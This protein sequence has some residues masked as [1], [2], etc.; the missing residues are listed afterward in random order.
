[1]SERIFYDGEC[2]LCHGFVRFVVARDRPGRFRFAPL[3]GTTYS[4]A[5][6]GERRAGLPDSIVVA[7]ADGRVLARSDAVAHVLATLGGG[8]RTL[9]RM[10]LLVPRPLRD[11]GYD[12][13]A[14]VRRRLFRRP[15]DLC[16]VVPRA[17]RGRFEP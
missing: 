6:P 1:V 7:A 10:L 9:A 16:P 15:P 3:Q 11:L 8:W 12:A 4:T 5:V 13:V 17:L 14:A 2:G